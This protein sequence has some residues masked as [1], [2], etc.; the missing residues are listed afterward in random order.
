MSKRNKFVV[1]A[2]L[3][4]LLISLLPGAI[5]GAADT[6]VARVRV[7]HF[8]PD[9]PAVQV[10]LDGKPSGI[11]ELSFGNISGWV[12]IPA[13]TYSVAVA[14][15]GAPIEQAA[16]G[17]VSL[18]FRAGT[19]TTVAAI[20]SLSSGSLTA[21]AIN[22]DYRPLNAADSR[23]TVF[24]GIEDAPAVD[25]IL[26]DGSKVVSNLAFGKSAT[27][28]VP[29]NVYDLRVVP[30]GASSPVV[31]NLA[32]TQLQS[33]TYYFVAATNTLATPQVALSAIS[34]GTVAPL[35]R[36]SVPTH[37]IAEIAAGDARFST[38]V[39]A[40]KAAGLVDTLNG[41]GPFT[42]FAPT[43]AAFAKLPAATLNAVLA[44]KDLLTKILL[45][46][47]ASGKALA[48]DVVKLSSIDTL[49]GKVS[50]TVNSDGV[51][52]NGNVKVIITDIQATNGVIH[53]IDTV[54]IP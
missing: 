41:P 54:L 31:I 27:V 30:A 52:L 47:V 43:N 49:N 50:V 8:S 53:V 4:T 35:I 18:R 46:H 2:L 17:P 34:L 44:D 21:T 25:V 13:G 7:A 42:V 15:A 11:Q 14:P 32:G 23:V 5:A 26:P 40:L 19:W 28:T 38:L 37:T 20:G 22:E 36:D 33:A 10:F 12:E 6:P 1:L 39:T 3:L 51:F 48:S 45:Y 16:I 9:T 29:A 24:H